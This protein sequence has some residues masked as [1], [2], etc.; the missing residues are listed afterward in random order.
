MRLVVKIQG[1]YN[2]EFYKIYTKHR[3]CMY[4]LYKLL[5]IG[6]SESCLW[7]MLVNDHDELIGECSIQ[8]K[9]N[10]IG[11]TL[12]ELHNVY[13]VE[14][15]R[16]NNF[17]VLMIVNV[18]NYLD[19]HYHEYNYIIKANSDNYPAINTYTK[20]AGDPIYKNGFA[21]FENSKTF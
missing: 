4:A 14:K 2:E 8:N 16:G 12:F 6:E 5:S 11:R 21:F 7:F 19:D 9:S 1:V 10:S 13:I 3:N 17:A 15:Y 18:L 20:I